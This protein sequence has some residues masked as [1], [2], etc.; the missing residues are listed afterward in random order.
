M[1]KETRKIVILLIVYLIALWTGFR[2]GEIYN[3]MKNKIKIE[4]V[5]I[6]CVKVIPSKLFY[7]VEKRGDADKDIVYTEIPETDIIMKLYF[8]EK[9]RP[10]LKSR[11]IQIYTKNGERLY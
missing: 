6:P 1:S 9:L 11:N 3:R 4:R 2:S 8:N 5:G 7:I 10:L